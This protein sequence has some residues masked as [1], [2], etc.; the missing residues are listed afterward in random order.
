MIGEEDFMKRK[1]KNCSTLKNSKKK[2]IKKGVEDFEEWI[3]NQPNNKLILINRLSEMELEK[4]D[5]IILL[6]DD[7]E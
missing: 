2:T 3:K 6:Q 7:K 4:R 5:L 1:I